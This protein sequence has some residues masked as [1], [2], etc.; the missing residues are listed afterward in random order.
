M[1]DFALSQS[2]VE[3][4]E[5]VIE[6]GRKFGI[7]EDMKLPN[8]NATHFEKL[9]EGYFSHKEQRYLHPISTRQNSD[10]K[11]SD[12]LLQT[13]KFSIISGQSNNDWLKKILTKE[14]GPEI[15]FLAEEFIRLEN[16]INKFGRDSTHK[17]YKIFDIRKSDTTL[18]SHVDYFNNFKS[19]DPADLIDLAARESL[20][21]E[22]SKSID[23]KFFDLV[24]E[25][26]SG[27][28]NLT[29]ED[30]EKLFV[31]RTSQSIS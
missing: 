9:I 10:P 22:T 15:E 18:E 2:R 21:Q 20:R 25:I 7:E 30:Y 5:H 27:E 14:K 28:E 19:Q 13:N 6:V 17:K 31:L 1:R 16:S 26:E 11:A 12:L 4:L 3:K 29:I 8:T 23:P 24:S